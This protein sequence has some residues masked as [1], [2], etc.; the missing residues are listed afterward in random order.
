M[1]IYQQT[2]GFDDINSVSIELLVEH[3]KSD[4]F[5]KNKF[6]RH[7]C[8]PY[9][10]LIL[11]FLANSNVVHWTEEIAEV[12][13]K[14]KNE[15]EFKGL[16]FF[17][18]EKK[19]RQGFA[20][21]KKLIE[22]GY[23]V[24]IRLEETAYKDDFPFF[25]GES[26][27]FHINRDASA[28]KYLIKEGLTKG[29]NDKTTIYPFL[30]NYFLKNVVDKIGSLEQ[31]QHLYA[32]INEKQ[33]A[34]IHENALYC[35]V[36]E[37]IKFSKNTVA[38]KALNECFALSHK[39]LTAYET[40]QLRK[41]RK[42]ELV[43]KEFE[44]ADNVLGREGEIYQKLKALDHSKDKAQVKKLMKEAV[45]TDN[46]I[47]FA[48]L[49][50]FDL[51][52]AGP[53]YNALIMSI[54]NNNLKWVRRIIDLS[55]IKMEN[56]QLCLKAAHDYKRVKVFAHLYENNM[57][58]GVDKVIQNINIMLLIYKEEEDSEILKK[59]CSGIVYFLAKKGHHFQNKSIIEKIINFEKSNL[60]KTL[61]SIEAPEV[62]KSFKI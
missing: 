42:K 35:M 55:L 59:V 41:E 15:P 16:I 51:N 30:Y 10:R 36:Q 44:S 7:N 17:T 14:R 19:V 25:G 39:K 8:Y 5:S 21:L 27:I 38:I 47:V 23:S 22:W 4:D 54:K 53:K 43:L 34:V 37:Y 45:E 48:N 40:A 33:R 18:G 49:H 61:Q 62:R 28:I 24:D 29:L 60:E 46:Q 57:Q 6:K 32:N 2:S 9:D 11:S 31:L 12:F 50:E 20:K 52:A 56:T 3:L 58:E 26:N 13:K 1:N